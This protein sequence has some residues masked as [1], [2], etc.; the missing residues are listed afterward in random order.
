MTDNLGLGWGAL[1]AARRA[2]LHLSQSALADLCSVSQ[3]TISKI[4]RGLMVP[5]DPLKLRLAAG[6]AI[7]P[8]E[9][10]PWPEPVPTA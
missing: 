9:L 6:L 2:E 8:A 5:L 7:H 4:E 3:Q 10:F 1:I